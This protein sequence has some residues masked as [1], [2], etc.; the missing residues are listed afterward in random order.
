MPPVKDGEEPDFHRIGALQGTAIKRISG[1]C[2][3]P[4]VELN[5]SSMA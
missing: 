2:D 3:K 5:I 1:L 4:L